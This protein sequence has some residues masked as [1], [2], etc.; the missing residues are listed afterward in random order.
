MI[1]EMFGRSSQ[2]G[3]SSSNHGYRPSEASPEQLLGMMS[4]ELLKDV[5]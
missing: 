4:Q 3:A 5:V 2:A 1:V